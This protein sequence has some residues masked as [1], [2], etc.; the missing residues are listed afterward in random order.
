MN[1][2]RKLQKIGRELSKIEVNHAQQLVEQMQNYMQQLFKI[3]K[4]S[5]N[6]KVQNELEIIEDALAEIWV[7]LSSPIRRL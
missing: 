1:I 2:Q 4:K 6:R 3:A 5:K 7:S